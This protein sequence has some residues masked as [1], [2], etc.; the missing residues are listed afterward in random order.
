M[1]I[2]II[3]TIAFILF[4]FGLTAAIAEESRGK[5]IKINKKVEISYTG[6]YALLIGESDYTASG[7]QDLNSIPSEL[8][9]VEDLLKSQGFQV[10]TVFNLNAS[11]LRSR[12]NHFFNQYGAQKNNRLLFFYS[13]HGHTHN[14]KGYL[15]PI[16]APHPDVNEAVFLQK[17]L[18]MDDI[19][20][21]ARRFKAKH[22]LF[23]FD[24]C[25][26]GM[27]FKVREPDEIPRQIVEA[28]ALPV[29]Q[30]ITAGRANETVPAESVFTPAFVNALRFAWG[31]MNGDGYVTGQELGLYLWNKVPQ[32]SRQ[33]PQYGKI[34]D[35][36]LS[37]GDFVFTV[38]SKK[39]L[40][41]KVKY[42]YRHKGEAAFLR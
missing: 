5:V 29:R 36:D 19:I 27:L 3:R 31:D 15:V 7:W 33:T 17:A 35:Y 23:L 39:S 30:F 13:G 12:I 21:W 40:D 28:T 37:R 14:D 41:V 38:S 32:S 18:I 11:Q 24:S 22:A 1:I 10:Q 26:S 25:F 2:S 9:P 4:S 42:I 8:Q 6:S 20:T 16:D 34:T